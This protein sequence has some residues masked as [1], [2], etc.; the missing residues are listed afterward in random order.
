MT[1]HLEKLLDHLAEPGQPHAI[2]R[3]MEAATQALVGHRLFTLL[4]VDGQDVARVWSSDL[5]A[6][7]VSG[8]KTMG[9]TPWGR[10]V[11]TEKRA[12]LGRDMAAIRW[13][14]Y[15]HE[16]IASLGCGSAI[17]IPVVYDGAAIG[18]INLL[19]AE[20]AYR[21]EHVDLVQP[22]AAALIPAFLL[23]RLSSRPL[24]A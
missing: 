3:A 10:Q 18:T 11:L 17:N 1:N 16:L 6:Y 23:A 20:F 4:S 21:E 7:P 14:F 24:Q 15:D 13:A 19:D 12:F 2:Y 5:G 22:L 8:R 9:A